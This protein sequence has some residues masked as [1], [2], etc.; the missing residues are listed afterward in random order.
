M[1]RSYQSPAQHPDPR[2]RSLGLEDHQGN[3]FASIATGSAGSGPVKRTVPRLFGLMPTTRDQDSGGR[4]KCA[5]FSVVTNGPC[6]AYVKTSGASNSPL[7]FQKHAVWL[8][9]ALG[10]DWSLLSHEVQAGAARSWNDRVL[11]HRKPV[12]QKVISTAR[13]KA[14]RAASMSR[15]TSSWLRMAGRRYVNPKTTQL[16]PETALPPSPESVTQGV[17]HLP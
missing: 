9:G 17:V 10:S 13:W 11:A 5:A 8:L 14:G 3:L 6:F 15:A 16:F 1:P 7:V 2:S 4:L 12:A